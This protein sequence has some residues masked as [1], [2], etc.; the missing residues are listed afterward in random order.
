MKYLLGI[1]VGTAGTK[2]AL[3]TEK[4]EFVDLA[5]REYGLSY[6]NEGWVEQNPDDWWRALVDT[7]KDVTERNGCRKDVVA[8]SLSTQGGAL[9]LLDE[10]FHVLYPAVSWLDVR[11]EET[12][13]K[14]LQKISREELYRMS[15]WPITGGLNLPVVFWFREKRPELYRESRF[16]ASTIDYINYLLT[17]RFAIDYTNL[18]L[19]M[20]LDLEERDW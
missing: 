20:F 3:F 17:G 8:L 6:P 12:A 14:L 2:S 18:A 19:T 10:K 9:V 7:A 5:C 1:D 15:G 11:A 16:F 4:G 13:N